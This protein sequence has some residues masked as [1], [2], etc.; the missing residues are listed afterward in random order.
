VLAS[1]AGGHGPIAFDAGGGVKDGVAAEAAD[2]GV[3]CGHV[4]LAAD[5]VA[6][7]EEIALMIGVGRQLVQHNAAFVVMDSGAEDSGQG[8]AGVVDQL[9]SVAGRVWQLKAGLAAVIGLLGIER[10]LVQD[11]RKDVNDTQSN[12][13]RSRCRALGGVRGGQRGSSRMPRFRRDS[14]QTLSKSKQWVSE[15]QLKPA[16]T[17]LF[18]LS[19]LP[20]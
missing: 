10:A 18:G 3:E 1:H 8:V 12:A 16:K 6:G 17:R 7:V 15:A 14:R 20:A 4:L 9:G 13:V 5:G 11:R 2:D 19:A